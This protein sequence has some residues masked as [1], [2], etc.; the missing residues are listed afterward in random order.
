MAIQEFIPP[1]DPIQVQAAIVIAVPP[2]HVAAIYRDL[3]TWHET[4][5]ATIEQAR[6]TETGDN[7]KQVEVI[8]RME[9]Q[10]PNKLIFLS[11]TEIAL[12]ESKKQFDAVFLNQFLPLAQRGTY[13]TLTAYIMLK[14]VYKL[15]KP[16]LQGYIRRRAIEQ[17]SRY[18]LEPLKRAAEQPHA[19]KNLETEL[20]SGSRA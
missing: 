14:G 4:F 12:E 13:Y 16:F 5:S 1:A 8:H 2:Q 7:W 3:E 20:S 17:M 19:N 10:V 11:E 9:G 15:L 6:I 18:V